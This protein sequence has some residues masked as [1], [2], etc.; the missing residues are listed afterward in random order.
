MEPNMTCADPALLLAMSSEDFAKLVADSIGPETDA[1]VWDA[2][3]HPSVIARTRTCLGSLHAD[4]LS[5]LALK[6]ANL[7][8]IRAEGQ[9]RGKEGKQDYFAA[10][11]ESADWRRR[12]QGFLRLI[13]R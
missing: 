5:Q 2:L 11:D 6:N 8:A 13:Q 10:V 1:R 7:H 3:T 9:A 4:V 12:T